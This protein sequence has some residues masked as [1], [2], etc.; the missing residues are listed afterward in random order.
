MM[1]HVIEDLAFF[2]V[3]GIVS[4]LRP[5][6][7]SSQ[8][9]ITLDTSFGSDVKFMSDGGFNDEDHMVDL[10]RSCVPDIVVA[11]LRLV[12]EGIV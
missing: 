4:W 7:A 10:V 1:M 9:K 12:A 3:G 6:G 11:Q 8:E 5:R 2:T